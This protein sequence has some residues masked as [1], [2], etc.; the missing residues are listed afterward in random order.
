MTSLV[1]IAVWITIRLHS[2]EFDV[3]DFLLGRVV[4]GWCLG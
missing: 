2:S 1:S 3:T 4:L